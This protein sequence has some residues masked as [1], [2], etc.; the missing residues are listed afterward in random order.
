MQ[1]LAPTVHL[2]CDENRPTPNQYQPKEGSSNR[3]GSLP[4]NNVPNMCTCTLLTLRRPS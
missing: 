4:K 1:N 2:A 3:F